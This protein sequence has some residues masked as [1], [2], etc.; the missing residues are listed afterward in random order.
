MQRD[1]GVS[2]YN[3]SDYRGNPFDGL[4]RSDPGLLTWLLK[5][6][7]SDEAKAVAGEALERM[8]AQQAVPIHVD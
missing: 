4:A 1:D 3:S 2:V 8:R 6:D 5:S 7:L